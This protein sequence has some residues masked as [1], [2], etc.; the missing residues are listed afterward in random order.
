MNYF[1]HKVTG[2]IAEVLL[3]FK[4]HDSGFNE[5]IIDGRFVFFSFALT[6][7]IIFYIFFSL[8]TAGTFLD[9]VG[10][11]KYSENHSVVFVLFGFFIMLQQESFYI[12]HKTFN[13]SVRSM[14]SFTG[15]DYDNGE[16]ECVFCVKTFMGASDNSY[17]FLILI[18][19]L[20]AL[21]TFDI[22]CIVF[23]YAKKYIGDNFNDDEENIE[24]GVEVC[25]E[26]ETIIGEENVIG[27]AVICGRLHP[28][29]HF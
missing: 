5:V 14:L 23:L 7:I 15:N 27:R 19:A 21:A 18:I 11:E 3:N 4:E 6:A 13:E 16:G 28:R 2:D 17:N 26:A 29:R 12:I 8:K 20:T 25:E 1:I 22:L 9:I 24:N 10:G